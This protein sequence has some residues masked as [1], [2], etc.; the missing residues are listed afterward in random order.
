MQQ[1]A[2]TQD[3][4]DVSTF[5]LRFTLQNRFD[6]PQDWPHL[7]VLL[8]DASGAVVV[9]KIVPPIDYVPNNLIDTAFMAQQESNFIVD[10]QVKGLA[11]SGF[12][13]DKFSLD[14]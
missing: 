3:G 10:L 13:I 14:A 12:E 2:S 1:I 7:L 11:I 5:K 4:S 8:T 9:R 6:K